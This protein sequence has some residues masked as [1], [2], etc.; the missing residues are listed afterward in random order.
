LL[1]TRQ[2]GQWTARVAFVDTNFWDWTEAPYPDALA[3]TAVD[4]DGVA[5]PAA[6]WQRVTAR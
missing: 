1:Q 5:G 3:V 2:G 6:V 4:L